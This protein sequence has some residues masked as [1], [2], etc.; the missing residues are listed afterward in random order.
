[1]LCRRGNI[2]GADIGAI[3]LTPGFSLVDVATHVAANF[4]RATRA[5]D[6]RD[7][8]VIVRREGTPSLARPATAIPKK[9]RPS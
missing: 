2:R 5:P 9:H 1:M 4:E 8:T 7:P 6:P 3:Q